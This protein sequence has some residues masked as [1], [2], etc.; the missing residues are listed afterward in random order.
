MIISKVK[1]NSESSGVNTK[2]IRL[3]GAEIAHVQH[4]D[5]GNFRSSYKQANISVPWRQIIFL[6][7]PL[8]SIS[9]FTLEMVIFRWIGNISKTDDFR[10]F[11]EFPLK[12]QLLGSLVVL[13]IFLWR[14]NNSSRGPRGSVFRSGKFGLIWIQSPWPSPSKYLMWAT[15]GMVRFVDRSAG[16]IWSVASGAENHPLE[17][18]P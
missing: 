16:S 9:D 14:H 7:M 17:Q 13:T 11:S 12:C 18:S 1:S 15:F 8:E 3:Q 4:L 2:I 10:C 6:L 5:R